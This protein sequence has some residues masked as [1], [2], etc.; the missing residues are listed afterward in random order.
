MEVLIVGCN[1]DTINLKKGVENYATNHSELRYEKTIEISQKC[2][3]SNTTIFV[4]KNGYGDMV[5]MSMKMY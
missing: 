3:A 2:H 5:I 4:P 1:C